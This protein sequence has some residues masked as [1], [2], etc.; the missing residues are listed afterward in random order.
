MLSEI[1]MQAFQKSGLSGRTGNMKA[2]YIETECI[3]R[4][5]KRENLDFINCSSQQRN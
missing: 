5:S 1:N 3:N 2:F 4:Y